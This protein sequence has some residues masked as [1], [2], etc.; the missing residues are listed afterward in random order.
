MKISRII[1]FLLAIIS[2]SIIFPNVT[3]KKALAHA[4][5]GTYSYLKVYPHYLQ[6]RLII[7]G[8]DMCRLTGWECDDLTP[9]DLPRLILIQDKLSEKL[10][11]GIKISHKGS[12]LPLKIIAIK[13]LPVG[14]EMLLEFS[15]ARELKS[16]TI[17]YTLLEEQNKMYQSFYCI[18]IAGTP[19]DWSRVDLLDSKHSELSWD[20]SGKREIRDKNMTREL[21][22][23][24]RTYVERDLTL[25]WLI[26]GLAVAVVLGIGHAFTP[27]HGKSIMAAYLVGSHGHIKDAFIMGL[28]TTAT[29]TF[30]VILIGIIVMFFSQFILPSTLYPLIARASAVLIVCTGLYI[31]YSRI[32]EKLHKNDFSEEEHHIHSHAHGHS[33]SHHHHVHDQKTTAQAFWLAFSGGLIPCPAALTVLL[34]GISVGKIGY[35]IMMILVFSIG[36]GGALVLLGV[37]IVTSRSFFNR[38]ESARAYVK[39]LDLIGPAFIIFIGILFLINGPFGSLSP[40]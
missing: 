19:D 27:G 40:L 6:Y 14:F 32:H 13:S 9:D 31:L 34:G 11:R 1:I 5:P 21:I 24:L 30:S 39:Y 2:L 38:M 4:L 16:F 29:H 15:S 10:R 36:L 12:I 28:T 26:L 17:H 33:H 35:G 20:I 8:I 37:L 25:P 18:S 23:N 22:F 7:S 3:Q